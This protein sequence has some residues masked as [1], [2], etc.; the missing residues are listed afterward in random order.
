MSLTPNKTDKIVVGVDVGTSGVRVIAADATGGVLAES[1][2]PLSSKR[3]A[4][5]LIHEQEPEEWWKAVCELVRKTLNTLSAQPGQFEIGGI[6]VTSTS[7]TLVLAG[8]NGEPLRPAILYD[9]NRAALLASQIN[10]GMNSE[11]MRLNASQSLTKAAWVRQEEPAVWERVRFILHPADWLT[12]QFTGEYGV[13]DTSNVLK[14]G[15]EAD[16]KG[17]NE[18]LWAVGIVPE[19]LPTV[20]SPGDIVGAICDRAS[21]ETGLPVRVPVMAGATDGVASLIASGACQFGDANTTL[22]TTLVWKVLSKQKPLTSQGVYCHIHPCGA[23]IPGAASNTGPGSLRTNNSSL[24]IAEMGQLV[25]QRLPV[26]L[27]CY[28]LSG[29][30]ERF[31]FENARAE[32]FFERNARDPVESFAAQLQAIGFTERWGYEVLKQCGVAIGDVVYS[33]GGASG[34]QVFSQMRSNIFNRS[35]IRC[36]T[37][38]AAFGACILAA[39]PACYAGDFRAAIQGMTSVSK[40]FEPSPEKVERYNELYGKFRLACTSRGYE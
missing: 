31:P 17:W 18:V 36:Q 28:M 15:H 24:T 19:Q 11:T 2:G 27:A 23:W 1:S 32:T 16:K 20:F 8:S 37:P 26:D 14:L 39:A 12:S 25:A 3:S 7:G 29:R 35:I 4:D 34:S 22:G 40:R 30:G 33:T 5:G 13:S 38:A 6:A 9:D 10:D 21:Q